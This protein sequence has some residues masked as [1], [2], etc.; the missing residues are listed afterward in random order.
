MFKQHLLSLVSEGL[1]DLEQSQAIG[2]VP[3]NGLSESHFFSVWIGKALNSKRFDIC[4]VPLL[5]SWQ[6]QA[7]TDGAGANLKSHF[8]SL[9]KTYS[10]AMQDTTFTVQTIEQL[11]QSLTALQWQVTTDTTLGKKTSVKSD[12][13][14]SLVIAPAD[15]N[16][17]FAKN[18][19]LKVYVRGDLQQFVDSC[20]T[21]GL[22]AFK[23]TDYKS[24]VK[25]HSYFL[26]DSKNNHQALPQYPAFYS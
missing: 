12:G 10:N 1:S 22:L 13:L 3:K 8:S 15:F 24:I 21:L 7:R 9:K 4:V 11:C 20:Y 5:K 6:Q 14:S 25:F 19:Q 23:V 16:V 17:G 18:G 2:K 26:L